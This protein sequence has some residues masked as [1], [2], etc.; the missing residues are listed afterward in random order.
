MSSKMS[1]YSS[2][3]QRR[4]AGSADE[5]VNRA[6]DPRPE[7]RDPRP[8]PLAAGS[9][10]RLR[11]GLISHHH[12]LGAQ[13]ENLLD[14]VE[15]YEWVYEVE[16]PMMTRRMYVYLNLTSRQFPVGRMQ[17][18]SE[19][20]ANMQMH[21]CQLSGTRQTTHRGAPR[22]SVCHPVVLQHFL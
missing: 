1:D 2:P 15:Q 9:P 12:P 5:K 20:P 16:V 21:H 10:Q 11:T 14:T 22:M 13:S 8:E 4:F 7:T 3:K 17:Q 18:T 6:V 19:I